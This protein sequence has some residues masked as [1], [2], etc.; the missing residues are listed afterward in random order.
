M[1][2]ISVSQLTKDYGQ[3]FKQADQTLYNAKSTGKNKVCVIEE[4]FN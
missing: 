4:V 3:S 2:E 1:T